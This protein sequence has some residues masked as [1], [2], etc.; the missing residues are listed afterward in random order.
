MYI[1]V[2][3]YCLHHSSGRT[4]KLSRP[5]VSTRHK[6]NGSGEH[7]IKKQMKEKEK[8]REEANDYVSPLDGPFSFFSPLPSLLRDMS[9]TLVGCLVVAAKASFT[10]LSYLT[11]HVRASARW[12]ALNMS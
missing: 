1:Y 7:T 2:G 9:T 5:S 4:R 12:H 11:P 3:M 6:A 8:T 10:C